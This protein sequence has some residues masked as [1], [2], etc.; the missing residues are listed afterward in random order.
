MNAHFQFDPLKN[1][2]EP[3][4][5]C[6]LPPL[7]VQEHFESIP[8]F[9]QDEIEGHMHLFSQDLNGNLYDDLI[10]RISQILL[11]RTCQGREV[12]RVT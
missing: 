1:S 10:S 5:F 12:S 3:R 2:Q 11:G 6:Q 9:S 7:E 8:S 4:Y